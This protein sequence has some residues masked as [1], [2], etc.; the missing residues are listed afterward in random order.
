MV[1]LL[2]RY[3]AL[4]SA[5]GKGCQVSENTRQGKTAR[6][7]QVFGTPDWIEFFLLHRLKEIISVCT[8]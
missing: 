8:S 5:G 4:Q 2:L 1:E 3:D 7:G 6:T